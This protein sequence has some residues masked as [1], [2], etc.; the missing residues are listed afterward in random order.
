MKQN[1]NSGIKTQNIRERIA[2]FCF[3]F[4]FFLVFLPFLGPL[5]WHMEVLRLGV[6]LE[7]Q[8]LA[9]T[10]A[11]T[12]QD[13]S[14]VCGLQHSSW[15]HQ[16]LNP[17]IEARNGACILMDASRVCYHWA[18][19]GTPKGNFWS[20]NILKINKSFLYSTPYILLFCKE[21]EI[22]STRGM[23]SPFWCLTS[24]SLITNMTIIINLKSWKIYFDRETMALLM[25]YFD[26]GA[27][28]PVEENTLHIKEEERS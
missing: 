23:I 21:N 2:F 24:T 16:I 7:L 19:I 26:N 1:E 27:R 14:C 3:W 20:F 25:K 12:T 8:P 17:L 18:M 6:E 5:L 11:T 10:K 28:S 9:Y 22:L 13:L 4:G 15:Q